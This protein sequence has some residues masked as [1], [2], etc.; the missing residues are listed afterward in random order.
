MKK[1]QSVFLLLAFSWI[2]QAEGPF[3]GPTDE[4]YLLP[5]GWTLTPIG[6]QIQTEDQILNLVLS[7]DGKVAVALTCGFNPHGLV[8]IDTQTEEA[9]QRIPQKTAWLGMAWH[10]DGKRLYVSGGN[11]R[12]KDDPAAPVYVYGY[13]EGKLSETA[14]TTLSVELPKEKVFWSG[15]VHHPSKPILYALNRMTNEVVLFDTDQGKVIGT[16]PTEQSPYDLVLSPDGEDLYV[17]NWGSDTVSHFKTAEGRLNSVMRVGDNPCDLIL[18]RNGR[19]FVCCSNENRVVII[20]TRRGRPVETLITSLYERAPEGS[21]PN[22]LALDPKEETLFIANADNNNIA[23]AD[24]EET[25]EG[26]VLGFIPVGWYPSALAVSADGSKLFVGNSK[27][28]ASY[29]NVDG[30]H[31]PKA[32]ETGKTVTTKS[33]QKGAVSIIDAS[34]CRQNMLELT[35]QVYKNCPYRDELLVL[36]PEV[37]EKTTIVPRRVG[38]G[39]P[40][41]HVIY[42]IKE[43]RTYD[44]VLGDLP[45]GKGDPE[46]CLF[47]REITPNIHNLVETYVLFD[48]LYCDAEVS[49][50]GHQWSNAAYAT[51]YTEKN[52]PAEYGGWSDSPRSFAI[53]PSSGYLWDQCAHKGLTY[54]TYGEFAERQSEDGIMTPI[55]P[56]LGALH[57]HVA[58][59]YL[60]WGARDTE[61]AR[62]F[63]RE[64]DEYEKNYDSTDPGKRLPNFIVMALPEDHTHG[65]QPGAHTPRACVASNDYALG[66]IV[67]RVSRSRYWPQTAIFVIQ[68]DAQD[69]PDHIDAR[70]TE[71]LV[72]SP[73]SLQGI[74]DSTLYTTSSML[75]TIELVLGL[76][77]MSQFDA[78]AN[79]MYKALG[80]NPNIK[81][82]E[83]IPPKIDLNETNT[84]TAWGAEASMQMDFSSYDRTPMFELNEIIW[85]SVKGADSEMPL[86]VHRFQA[87]VALRN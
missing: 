55:H 41:K 73:Y 68:D 47:G 10:P 24:V 7:P 51:D 65:T 3:P 50:D 33:G 83:V 66:M 76:Q 40:I 53:Y 60:S 67:E 77:P 16:W 75:R 72:I 26:T 2:A 29:S 15:L 28:V 87:A 37:D 70:R 56:S 86:P 21:T 12:K 59:H 78:A 81:P 5:N 38:A 48:N 64:F 44:Q 63:I 82:Y 79:P 61:N 30:P 35:R 52:W 43:N 11:T 18:T 1:P 19:L 80:V 34:R 23:V 49:V 8:V 58:P 85:K 45:Q 17:S 71:G 6:K 74:V 54:R 4:G 22:A 14:S 25:G 31:S 39:S 62:E 36:A 27:G 57:G 42:I 9:I 20:D 13:A 84:K 32:R 69:G 46:L